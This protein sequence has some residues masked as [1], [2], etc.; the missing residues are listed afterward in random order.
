MLRQFLFFFA[1]IAIGIVTGLSA[2][3]F[4]Y[5]AKWIFQVGVVAA[6]TLSFPLFSLT[7]LILMVGGALIAGILMEKFAPD[8]PGSGIPQVK[9]A[10]VE[11]SFDFS[12]NLLW[13]KF[14]GGLLT[15][16]TGSSLGREGPTVHI[17]A[18]LGTKIAKGVKESKEAIANATCA[19]AAGGLAAA[20]NSP[21]AGVT[22]VRSGGDRRK[23]KHG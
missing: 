7:A 4:Q 17:G 10:Y 8:A 21:L 2:L 23:S 20:F 19:G 5:G 16:G 13:V 3:G 18:A 12:W 11:K 15:I 22:L 9:T 6:S 14:F 1:T